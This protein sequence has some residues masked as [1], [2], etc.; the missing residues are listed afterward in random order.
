MN[1]AL[2]EKFN[3]LFETKVSDEIVTMTFSDKEPTKE[4]IKQ[5]IDEYFVEK[6]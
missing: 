1:K 2:E 4:D 6:Q 3:E 5:F